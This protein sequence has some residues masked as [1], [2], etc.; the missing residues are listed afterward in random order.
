MFTS[1]LGYSQSQNQEHLCSRQI[2]SSV[3]WE[4]K[5]IEVTVWEREGEG[6]GDGWE[7][8]GGREGG[9][10]TD[11]GYSMVERGRGKGE[12]RGKGGPKRTGDGS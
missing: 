9:R 7:V 6:Q 2:H 5:Q 12:G 1:I 11:R 4:G 8:R 10:E 3:F